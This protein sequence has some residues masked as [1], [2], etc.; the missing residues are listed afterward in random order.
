MHAKTTSSNTRTSIQIRNSSN[1][2][3]IITS[4]NH[5]HLATVLTTRQPF[6]R[7]A[8]VPH[9]LPRTRTPRQSS[10]GMTQQQPRGEKRS[11]KKVSPRPPQSPPQRQ[12]VHVAEAECISLDKKA[13]SVITPLHESEWNE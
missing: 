8:Y 7:K 12:S 10:S 9:R 4:Q 11:G 13:N 3:T 1:S 2:T 5:T 6:A